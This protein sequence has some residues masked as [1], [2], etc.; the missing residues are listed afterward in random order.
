MPY[1][2]VNRTTDRYKS[3]NRQE[4][5]CPIHSHYVALLFVGL[6][7][8]HSGCAQQA[9][10]ECSAHQYYSFRPYSGYHLSGLFPDGNT[11][12]LFIN[13]YGYRRGVVFGLLLFGVG[14]LLFIPGATVGSF[15]AFLL[16]LFIIG[17]GLVFLETAANPYVTELGAKETA[18]S[19][20]NL[21]QSFNGLGGILPHFASVSS[22]STRPKRAAMWWCLIP[23]WVFWF[24]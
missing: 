19:R 8:C 9:L 12:W 15:S 24:W 2:Y 23:F 21:S 11:C 22:S 17:C 14:A 6:R 10:P 18:T 13:R 5:S 16:C 3:D 7:S 20:L 4:I 1:E